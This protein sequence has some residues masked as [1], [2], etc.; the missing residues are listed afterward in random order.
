MIPA[1]KNIDAEIRNADPAA[2]P[3]LFFAAIISAG[4]DGIK[5]KISYEPIEKNIY[6]MTEQEIKDHGIIRLPTN[7]MEALEEFESDEVIYQAIG[8]DAADLYIDTKKD[9]WDQYMVEIT[10]L[11]NLNFCKI[12]K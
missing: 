3:Y 12:I 8:K 11:L 7:L 2:N 1:K 5:K 9:E 10:D 6:Q 4:L